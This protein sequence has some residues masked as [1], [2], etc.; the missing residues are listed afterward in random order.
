MIRLLKSMTNLPKRTKGGRPWH[1][2]GVRR[3]VYSLQLAGKLNQGANT[4]AHILPPQPLWAELC[5][6]S[7]RKVTPAPALGWLP[8]PPQRLRQRE[9]IVSAPSTR[10][11]RPALAAPENGQAGAARNHTASEHLCRSAE[12]RVRLRGVDPQ[13]AGVR[14]TRRDGVREVMEQTPSRRLLQAALPSKFL[15]RLIRS[16]NWRKWIGG[17]RPKS[18]TESGNAAR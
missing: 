6:V 17:A 18:P 1:I 4:S 3:I 8:P 12:A 13:A 7:A 15:A 5:E 11:L 2:S 9:R 16:P 14:K 10:C